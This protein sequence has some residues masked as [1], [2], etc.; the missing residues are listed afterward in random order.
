MEK[1]LRRLNPGAAKSGVR[2]M[3]LDEGW[4]QRIELLWDDGELVKLVAKWKDPASRIPLL[5][6]PAPQMG[7]DGLRDVFSLPQLEGLDLLAN[8]LRNRAVKEL[9]SYPNIRDLTVEFRLVDSS[10]V[11]AVLSQIADMRRL[12]SFAFEGA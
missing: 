2:K 12:A 11:D 3:G 1:L 9:G 8:V 6:R 5:V 4:L 10:T 7:D